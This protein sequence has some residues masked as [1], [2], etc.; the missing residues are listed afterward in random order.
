MRR[1]SQ[2]RA[3]HS[4]TEK[5]TYNETDDLRHCRF[6]TEIADVAGSILSIRICDSDRSQKTVGHPVEH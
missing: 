6:V 1:Q 3:E 5:S 4:G 2:G